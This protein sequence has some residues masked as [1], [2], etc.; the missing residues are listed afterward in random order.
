[1]SRVKFAAVYGTVPSP[2]AATFPTTSGEAPPSFPS[3]SS[4]LEHAKTT[5]QSLIAKQ[6]PWRELL[7]F[8]AFSLP[9]SSD[10]AMA[11]IR[12]NVNYFHV[13]YAMV[14]LVI[15]FFS[16]FW[17]PTSFFVILLVFV[18]WLFFYFLRDQPLVLFDQTFDDK[19]VLGVLSIFTIIA[20]VSTDVGS[21][22]LGALTT[23]TVVV[24]LH[25]AFRSTA[26]QFLDLE[27]AT[28]GGLLSAAG[29]QQQQQQRGY[30]RI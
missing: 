13:N 21:N 14:M 2:P 16:L 17:H 18:A 15:V 24:A 10:D 11:R 27:T 7:D 29:N 6:R 20:L 4:F 30:T 19:V 26:D 3:S 25:A 9:L 8:S 1:M 22:V 23:G 5:T 12:Q 28:Q